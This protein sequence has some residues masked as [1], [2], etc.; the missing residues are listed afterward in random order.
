[1]KG[2][3]TVFAEKHPVEEIRSAIRRVL[4]T[5]DA[6]GRKPLGDW[7]RAPTVQPTMG[8]VHQLQSPRESL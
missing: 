7:Q 4:E 8:D 6:A 5:V 1:M 3:G 2:F